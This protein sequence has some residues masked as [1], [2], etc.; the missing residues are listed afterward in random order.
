MNERIKVD[1]G[2]TINMGNYESLRI[3]VGIETDIGSKEIREE[4]IQTQMEVCQEM[5]KEMIKEA[6]QEERE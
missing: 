6:M 3:S 1:Y 5:V 4:V 2:R